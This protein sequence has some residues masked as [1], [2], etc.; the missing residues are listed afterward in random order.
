M[1]NLQ[2]TYM[3]S[4]VSQTRALRWVCVAVAGVMV[5]GFGF[6]APEV[7][8]AD[9]ATA[10]V[11]DTSLV[12]S[13]LRQTAEEAEDDVVIRRGVGVE[14][15]AGEVGYSFGG[16][17][18]EASDLRDKTCAADLVVVARPQSEYPS[19]FSEDGSAIFTVR[20]F[21]VERILRRSSAVPDAMPSEIVVG[22]PGGTVTVHAHKISV[23]RPSVAEFRPAKT[24]LLFLR[25]IP[26]SSA[27][28]SPAR[29]AYDISQ[30]PAVSIVGAKPLGLPVEDA[31]GEIGSASTLCPYGPGHG[32]LER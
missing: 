14:D 16:A 26:G 2:V 13:N 29:S 5:S 28:E 25:A 9:A 24:Y 30:E 12:G 7:P 31:L 6:G 11:F 20:R 1:R 23:L 22:A 27:F 17:T 10:K 3:V 4:S 18:P 32:A 8:I 21:T 15:P 19:A